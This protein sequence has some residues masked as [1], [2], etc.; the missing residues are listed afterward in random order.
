MPAV[1]TP[2]D[3]AA[4]S[5]HPLTARPVQASVPGPSRVAWPLPTADDV[6]PGTSPRRRWEASVQR[7]TL[8][9]TARL[10]ALTLATYPDWAE[11]PADGPLPE[12]QIG[13]VRISR[14]TGLQQGPVRQALKQMH[15]AGWIHRT[16]AQPSG[17]HSSIRL[18]L[19]VVPARE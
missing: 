16:V 15:N 10:V 9:A 13:V 19:P 3:L 12:L 6:P 14:D 4:L 5:R 18:L 7:S 1:P 11:W 8:H 17:E 2:A